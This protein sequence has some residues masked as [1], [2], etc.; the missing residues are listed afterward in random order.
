MH[1]RV[2]TEG[3]ELAKVKAL[4]VLDQVKVP[5]E[6]DRDALINVARTSLRTKLYQEMADK[7]TEVSDIFKRFQRNV[8]QA[9][10]WQGVVLRL[11]L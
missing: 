3:F 8:L 10:R 6:M 1:P 11:S 4:E 9:L 5:M 2:I 7:M